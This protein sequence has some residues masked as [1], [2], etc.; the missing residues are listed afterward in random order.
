MDR[1]LGI[2]PGLHVTGFALVDSGRYGPYV[3]EAGVLRPKGD[4]AETLAG[5]LQFLHQGITEL[6]EE[7]EPHSL[8]LEQVHSR[9]KHPRT[10][11]LMAHA[12][13]V[14]ILAATQRK[15]SVVGYA[16][17]RVKKILTGSGKADK[18]QMQRAIQIELGLDQLPEPHDVADACAIA[19]CHFQV[20]RNYRGIPDASP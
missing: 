7:F 9:V 12:R 16:P 2:D 15:V 6:L 17:S 14:I 13:G 3:V 10:S 11:I 19:L 8:A 18:E 4:A 5:R 20:A 1:V